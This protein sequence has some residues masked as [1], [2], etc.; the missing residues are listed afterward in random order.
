MTETLSP[1]FE[2]GALGAVVVALIYYLH[3]LR[4]DHKA[5]R[6]EWREQADKQYDKLIEIVDRNTK[7]YIELKDLI[8]SKK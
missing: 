6:K 1:L 2:Y 5:E 4:K 3:H 7:A 8:I